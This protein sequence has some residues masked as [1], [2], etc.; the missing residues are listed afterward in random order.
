MNRL[1][2]AVITCFLTLLPGVTSAAP[3]ISEY[4]AALAA[5]TESKKLVFVYV[6]DSF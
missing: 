4:Q 2:F 3:P 1:G 6:H 5:A